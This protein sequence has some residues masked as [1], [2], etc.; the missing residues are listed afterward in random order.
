MDC[1]F[2]LDC[3]KACPHENVGILALAPGR[4]LARDPVRSNLGRFSRRPDMAALALVVVFSAFLS[5][6]AMVAPMVALRDRLTERFPAISTLPVTGL[7]FLLALVLVPALLVGAAV[8][9]GR[10]AAQIKKPGRELFCR[11]SLALLPVGLAVWVSHVL[12]HLSNAW[13]TAWPA[14]QQAAGEMGISWIGAPRWTAFGPLFAP[15]AM[16]AIQMLLLDGG[17]LW[18]LYVG[19]RIAGGYTDRTQDRLKLLAPWAV[20][21]A[22]LYAAGIWVFLQPMQMR[23]MVHG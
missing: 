11:F 20:V 5:A 15:D 22:L 8:W 2:C 21:V 9:V 7:F 17:V 4:D 6:G 13:S 16:L 3:V 18:S 14:A 1:T 23:G 12:F 10:T 19:W